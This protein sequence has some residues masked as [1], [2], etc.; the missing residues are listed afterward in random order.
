M[1]IQLLLVLLQT[2]LFTISGE[3]IMITSSY[4]VSDLRS[5]MFYS[6]TYNVAGS[7]ASMAID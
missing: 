1:A 3:K 4:I 2:L 6:R 7:I 5:P